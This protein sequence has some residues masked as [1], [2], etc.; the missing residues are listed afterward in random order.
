MRFL[1]EEFSQQLARVQRNKTFA[2][3]REARG[4]IKSLQTRV[5]ELEKEVYSVRIAEAEAMLIIESTEYQ[6]GKALKALAITKQ[7][8]IDDSRI[9]Q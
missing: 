7:V 4:T 2:E 5:E 9:E 1:S 8:C 3:L 6:L